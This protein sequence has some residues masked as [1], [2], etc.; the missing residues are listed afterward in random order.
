MKILVTNNEKPKLSQEVHCNSLE[1]NRKVG[2][3]EI[4]AGGYIITSHM[5]FKAS[6]V[7]FENSILNIV[8]DKLAEVEGFCKWLKQAESDAWTSFNRML[9]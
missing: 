6:S 3:F 7:E 2:S 4:P 9:D 1:Y 8:F 5:L